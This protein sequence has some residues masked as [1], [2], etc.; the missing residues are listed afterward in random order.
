[1]SGPSRFIDAA[2]RGSGAARTLGA[3]WL[4]ARVR[5]ELEERSGHLERLTPGSTWGELSLSG[6]IER[7]TGGLFPELAGAS[8]T[9]RPGHV[10]E[11]RARRD[12]LAQ[13]R[14]PIFGQSYPLTGWHGDPV[15]MVSY[16]SQDHWTA[17][18]EFD[19]ADLK[20][21]WE[22][23]RFGWAFDLARLHAVDPETNAAELFW[24]L[25][26][27]WC[28]ENEPNRGVNWL[29]GQESSLRLMAVLFTV[30]ALGGD[31]LTEERERL[32][33]G[34]ADVTA[35]RVQSHWRYARSQRNNHITS[36]A[37]GLLSAGFT[38][39]GLDDAAEW[40]ELGERLL[41]E[42]CDD[43]IF[44]DGG[45]SQYSLNYQRVFM[46]NFVWALWLYR[47]ALQ[48]PPAAVVDALARTTTLL[49]AITDPGTGAAGN[50]GH[51]DGAHILRLT[52]TTHGDMRPTIAMACGALGEPIPEFEQAT[53]EGARWLWG[54][55]PTQPVE[56]DLKNASAREG[57]IFA[58]AG[59][60]VLHADGG[61]VIMRGG[62]H[63]YR[64]AH[65]DHG[66]IE[67][68]MGDHQIIGDPGT[69][70]YKPAVGE[71]D[72]SG[73]A[74]HN[75]VRLEGT[76]SMTRLSRFLWGEWP[77]VTQRV[78]RADSDVP[79]LCAVVRTRDEAL[80][81]VRTVAPVDGGWR[82]RD[83]LGED[84]PAELTWM[85]PGTTA[86][87][88]A[89]D[90]CVITIE[91]AQY[92]VRSRIFVGSMMELMP[93]GFARDT[94]EIVSCLSYRQSDPDAVEVTMPIPAGSQRVVETLILHT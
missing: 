42:S 58:D 19:E 90:N 24:E 4:A 74:R 62:S 48:E 7:S 28:W 81:F 68:W 69:W 82:V 52:S 49:R 63:R 29:C 17:V 54:P 70:S 77:T 59:L 66:S 57:L 39:P 79:E 37:V 13:R 55:S 41:V 16:P 15:S 50:H 35:R 31:G 27:T 9:R 73:S 33:A 25:F 46:E 76:D 75:A 23:S 8:L 80:S 89:G 65:A 94:E 2:K 36:E 93:S 34:L 47:R 71:P 45:T 92:S 32:L 85:F 83:Y 60:S 1:M 6:S 5:M 22:P 30:E 51:N 40:R 64:P 10:A 44:D 86:V 12:E 11:L 67:V 88:P 61:R 43:L 91:N 18:P 78:E 20:V 3:P 84:E 21:V 72:L 26:E 87:V 38:Y 56:V 53:T 14:F